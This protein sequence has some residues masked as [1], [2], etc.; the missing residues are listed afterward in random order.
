MPARVALQNTQRR[1]Q[2]VRNIATGCSIQTYIMSHIFRRRD[3]RSECVFTID[4]MTARDLD[5]ALAVEKMK[6]GNYKVFRTVHFNLQQYLAMCHFKVSVHIADVSHFVSS[7]SE[8]DR[9]AAERATSV[10]LVQK[11]IP[12]LPRYKI[13]ITTCIDCSIGFLL[14]LIRDFIP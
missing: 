14:I 5:D 2:K 12:M 11:V 8:L 9:V 10:Y 3:Y 4:P 7:G 1:V 13:W 6:D